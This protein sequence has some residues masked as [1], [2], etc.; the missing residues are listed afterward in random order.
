LIGEVPVGG[1][2]IISDR[3]GAMIC[4]MTAAQTESTRGSLVT[5]GFLIITVLFFAATLLTSFF[6]IIVI[7]NE[8]NVSAD[9]APNI[10]MLGL[11]P[12]SVSTFLLYTKV[13]GRFI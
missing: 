3:L 1:L 13:F 6:I 12:P 8:T 11:V 5:L 2:N 4:I 10:F 7:I 9:M